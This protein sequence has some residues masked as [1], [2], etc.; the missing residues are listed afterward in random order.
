MTTSK[1]FRA[2]TTR[3]RADALSPGDHFDYADN[4]QSIPVHWRVLRTTTAG[5]HTYINVE[6]ALNKAGE[7]AARRSIMIERGKIVDRIQWVQIDQVK[8]ATTPES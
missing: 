8:D 6:T 1:L 5:D 4:P 3:M 7:S 2:E